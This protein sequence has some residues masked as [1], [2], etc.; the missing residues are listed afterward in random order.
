MR[1]AGVIAEYDP[2]H[3]G[4]AWQLARLRR[5]GAGRV[6]VCLSGPVVQRGTAALLPPAVRAAAALQAGADLVLALPA[7]W[8]S[9]SAE[10]FAAG[11]VAVLS[12]LGCVDTLAF[13]AE[14]PDA[15]A[16][17]SA[18]A[19]L[20][21][22]AF[23]A[24][25]RRL[26]DSPKAAN[27]PFAAL[28]A[29]AAKEVCPGADALLAGPNDNLGIEYCRAILRQKSPLRPLALPRQGAAHDAAAPG[30]GFAS[31]SFLR[32]EYRRAGVDALAP[33]L[34]PGIL[35]LYQKAE[36]E[37]GLLD[38]RAFDIA[39]LSRLR[40]MPPEQMAKTRGVREGLDRRLAAALRT[41]ADLETLYAAVKSRRYA[42]A[43]VRRLVL[44]AAL[45]YLDDEH[46]ALPAL[47]PYLHILAARRDALPLCKNA[48]LPCSTSLA[49]LA[50]QSPECAAVAAAEC[51]AA[52]LAALC[53]K[54]PGPMGLCYTQKPLLV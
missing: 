41:A 2:F 28:R 25:L 38:A 1:I 48:A 14:H 15:L 43:R 45:G 20:E 6:V 42:H 12:A 9:A 21:G 16:L 17:Q 8:A 5:L 32:A 46:G 52:D 31:G 34:P 24:A 36:A 29:A 37:G 26:L 4:H 44:D 39:V 23:A 35:P 7:P 40:A 49:R 11:G 22:P 18:A 19:A 50:A 27:Q 30:S 33:Y 47:P 54:A 10:G 51:A 3:A 53:R 13:G